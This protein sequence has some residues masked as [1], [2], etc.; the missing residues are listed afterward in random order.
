VGIVARLG[1]P[2]THV[3]RLSQG[4][5]VA[6]SNGA[7]LRLKV[8]LTAIFMLLAGAAAYLWF[9]VLH[10]GA[11]DTTPT[12]LW[13]AFW[14]VV[15]QSLRD[16]PVA[17]FQGLRRILDREAVLFTNTLVTA[18][19]TVLVGIAYA[20][21]HGRWSPLPALGR[22]ASDLLGIHAPLTIGTGVDLLMLAF[23]AG[24]VAAF[25]LAILLFVARR[26]PLGRPTP[27]LMP[28]YLRFTVPL[29][30]LFVGE[31][32]TK[33]VSQVLLGFWWDATTLGQFAAASKLS[34]LFL[35]LGV[36]LGI[37]LLPTISAL[38]AK[39]DQLRALA[40]VRDVERWTSL[41]L[42][43]IIAFVL[44]APGPILHILLS[45]DVRGAGAVLV[46]LSLQALATSLLMPVQNLAIASGRPGYAARI[47]LSSVGVDLLL[48]A[49]LIPTSLGP[50]HTFG[51]GALGAAIAAL[52]ATLFAL[53]LY[54]VPSG[55]WTGHSLL[56]PSFGRH[57]LAAFVTLAFLLFARV[58]LP[59][60]FYQLPFYALGI[61]VV[62]A[63]LLVAFRELRREDGRRLL[64][65]LRP[66][67]AKSP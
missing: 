33:W 36:S 17:T 6:A 11:T 65:L 28:L 41:L 67:T 52:A 18:L 21:S 7:F 3:R 50:F 61:V 14:I 53:L 16:I 32:L 59:E 58:P 62:Y 39:G 29:M 43:P 40:L 60:R 55:A 25:A 8:A 42:W 37:V 27:G 5:D 10:K 13:L 54:R 34:E 57:I 63:L 24:E 66:Q 30:L 20:D 47:I 12:A 49:V 4:E 48:D 51:L 31:A 23:F 22:W 35:L 38:H 2:T 19:L 64:D 45:N 1:L 56:Q 15:I 9:M 26:I 46:V 44:W